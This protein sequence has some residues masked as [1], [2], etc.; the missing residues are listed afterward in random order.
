MLEAISLRSGDWKLCLIIV[1]TLCPF[2]VLFEDCYLNFI[3]IVNL[4]Y[5]YKAVKDIQYQNI[6]IF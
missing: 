4:Y 3:R 2:V 1:S 6:V 5:L